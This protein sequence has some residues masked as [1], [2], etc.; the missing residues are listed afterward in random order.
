M[1]KIIIILML[2]GM[3]LCLV[4]QQGQ[5]SQQGQQNQQIKQNEKLTKTKKKM[6]YELEYKN[7]NDQYKKLQAQERE[8]HMK[9]QKL[10]KKHKALVK[11][12]NTNKAEVDALKK[13]NAML[14]A[15]RKELKVENA[16]LKAE[17]KELRPPKKKIIKKTIKG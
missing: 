16:K 6:N 13:A 10:D 12:S 1:K 4:A 14:Q 7:L 5:L 2:L 11:N 3:A 8:R 15:E 17:L 9:W